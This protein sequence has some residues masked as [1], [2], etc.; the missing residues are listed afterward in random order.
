[1]YAC[2]K[3][4]MTKDRLNIAKLVL[5]GKLSE[6]HLTLEEC[7]ELQEMVMDAV[8]A[9]M[10]ETNPFVFSGVDNNTLN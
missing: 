4:A 2:V 10:A 7:Y 8:I 3:Q 9:K 5:E 6:E 1:M